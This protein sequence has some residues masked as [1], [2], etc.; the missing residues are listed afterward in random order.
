MAQLTL[1]ERDFLTN[2]LT[3]S[4]EIVLNEI[5]GVRPDQWAF[6]PDEESWSMGECADHILTIE[7]RV[8]SM[9][10]KVMQTAPA[11]PV[12]AAEVQHK[13]P[14]LL[15]AVPSR[16]VRIKVPAGIANHTHTASPEEFVAPFE[17]QRA[18]L[19]QYVAETKDPVHD[20]VAPHPVFNDLDGC[21]WMLMIALH[22]ERH[23]HQMAELKRHPE[24]PK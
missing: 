10:S 12:R 6:R 8:F 3:R 21:Q 11:D 15:K 2:H 16:E 24:F 5:A 7:R 23:A 19:L 20:R 13:T 18:R 14:K 9:V 22:G 17:E 4:R 1:E